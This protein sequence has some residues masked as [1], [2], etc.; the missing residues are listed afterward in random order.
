MPRI[1][2]EN[3]AKSRVANDSIRVEVRRRFKRMTIERQ[4]VVVF[5][6]VGELAVEG[7]EGGEIGGGLLSVA[8][9]AR[10]AAERHIM[11]FAT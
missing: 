8:S 3:A 10:H 1:G 11:A 9:H 5:D 6:P 7:F 2:L 4:V